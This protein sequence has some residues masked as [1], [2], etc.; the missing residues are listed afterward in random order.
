MPKP[1]HSTLIPLFLLLTFPASPNYR[2]DEWTVGGGGNDQAQSPNYK[3]E[4]V[5]EPTTGDPARSSNF[6]INPGQLFVQMANVPP[7]PT[8][9]NSNN[10]YNKLLVVINHGNN[11]ADSKFLIAVSP[12]NFITTYY[13][14]ADNTI[15]PTATA[16]DWRTYAAFGNSSGIT[17]L[18]LQAGTTYAVKV[19]A[20][21]G[22]F[23]ESGWGPLAT[24]TTADPE[25]FF[26]IDVAAADQET[27]SPYVVNLGTLPSGSV[28]T[29]S[30]KIWV[31][32]ATN[33]DNGGVVYVGG[34]YGGLRSTTN[35]HTISAVSADLSGQQEGYG[36]QTSSLTQGADGPFT[37]DSPFN[38]AG[39][40]VGS[41]GTTLIP[42]NTSLGPITGGR[43][44]QDVKTIISSVT[45]AAT[46]YTET[47]TL[48]A[49]GMF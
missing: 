35:N 10:W 46:D 6:G 19:K 39:N 47:L 30:D 41:T 44:A 16:S 42:L 36:L 20:E 1:R 21:Q 37:A 7:A 17:I 14:K 8:V 2:L 3:T 45:P 12:D 26:D 18:G 40:T 13:V 4:T 38:G 22:S 34:T 11:P 48:V 33:A 29:A 5:L 32:F 9:T 25:I 15:G 31:D 27:A 23:T 49:V 28:T 43:S 24:A